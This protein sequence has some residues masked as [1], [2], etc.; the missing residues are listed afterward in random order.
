MS[1]AEIRLY[2]DVATRRDDRMSEPVPDEWKDPRV[3][4]KGFVEWAQKN[5]IDITTLSYREIEEYAMR[6]LMAGG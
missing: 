2:P 3:L 1:L 6:Y 4:I 5:G